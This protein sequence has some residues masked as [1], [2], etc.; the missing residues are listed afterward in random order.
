MEKSER[1][2]RSLTLS[3]STEWL[4]EAGYTLSGHQKVRVELGMEGG[5]ESPAGESGDTEILGQR[6]SYLSVPQHPSGGALT[7]T[8]NI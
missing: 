7:G 1:V 4:R 6:V 5:P 2:K 3:P 8:L